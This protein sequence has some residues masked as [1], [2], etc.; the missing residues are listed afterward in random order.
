MRTVDL[1]H[2]GTTEQPATS[3]VVRFDFVPQ[4]LMLLQPLRTLV[5]QS[6]QIYR[7]TPSLSQA[8]TTVCNTLWNPTS[9]DNE[10]SRTPIKR[11]KPIPFLDFRLATSPYAVCNFLRIIIVSQP[12]ILHGRIVICN[13]VWLSAV[14][15]QPLR[16]LAYQMKLI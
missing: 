14:V 15:K 5:Q 6:K 3:D 11:S 9:I 4:L 16:T 12:P 10:L 8:H 7:S 1:P 2:G 13:V